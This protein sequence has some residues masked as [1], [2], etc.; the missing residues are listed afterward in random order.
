MSL[1]GWLAKRISLSGRSVAEIARACGLSRATVYS[2]LS[3]GRVPSAAARFLLMEQLGLS[4]AEA[5][6]LRRLCDMA[7]VE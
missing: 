5:D 1:S 7:A 2:W 4:A 6:D 3:G